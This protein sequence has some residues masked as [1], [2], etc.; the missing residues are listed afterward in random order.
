MTKVWR[1]LSC[2]LVKSTK[3]KRSNPTTP[4]IV[5]IW[6]CC[7]VA[8][9]YAQPNLIASCSFSPQSCSHNFAWTPLYFCHQTANWLTQFECQL[10]LGCFFNKK[11]SIFASLFIIKNVILVLFSFI[12]FSIG[13]SIFNYL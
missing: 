13:Y 10:K 8:F 7:S 1:V 11:A 2:G 4:A 9:F 6:H 3:Q 12:L 5:A